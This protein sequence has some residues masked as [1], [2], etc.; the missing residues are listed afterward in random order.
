MPEKMRL[1]LCTDFDANYSQQAMSRAAD[2]VE[3]CLAI[4]PVGASYPM[5]AQ[6]GLVL[7][8][9]GAGTEGWSLSHIS[10]QS[11]ARLGKGGPATCG[12]ACCRGDS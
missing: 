2:G 1:G 8:V 5:P 11:P 6:A 12:L 9:L 7:W 10:R 3:N 4:K